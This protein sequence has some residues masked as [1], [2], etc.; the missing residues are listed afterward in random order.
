MSMLFAPTVVARR[1]EPFRA[2]LAEAAPVRPGVDLTR[3]QIQCVVLLAN[4][5]TDEEIASELA[6]SH[7]TVRFH[8]DSARRKFQARSRAHL[9]ALAVHAGV[10]RL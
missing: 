2:A 5:A 7:A 4:G 9:A 8:L 1:P 10:V 3:R 6:I